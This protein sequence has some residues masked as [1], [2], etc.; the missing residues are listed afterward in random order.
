L[1]RAKHVSI[2]AA[3]CGGVT[4]LTVSNSLLPTCLLPSVPFP[5]VGSCKIV[6][7]PGSSLD[8]I[9]TKVDA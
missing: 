9:A 7:V 4:G 6:V 8:K 2:I 1:Q 3:I 5:K